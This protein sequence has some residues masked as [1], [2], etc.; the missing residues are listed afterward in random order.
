MENMLGLLRV[1]IVR[2]VN[3]AIR[4]VRSSD[5]YVVLKMD[6]QSVDGGIIVF[7]HHSLPN[8][9]HRLIGCPD[10]FMHALHI[11]CLVEITVVSRGIL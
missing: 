5:P 10:H 11:G 2:G 4:D 7:S 9:F 6:K 3:L 8:F 1:R